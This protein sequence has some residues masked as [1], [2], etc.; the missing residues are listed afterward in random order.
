MYIPRNWEFGS[1]L[2]NFGGGGGG[3]E[4]SPS[5]RPWEDVF[6]VRTKELYICL[7]Q[8]NFTLGKLL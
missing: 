1:A 5:V 7:H 3:G 6:Y 4:T 2:A 8:H